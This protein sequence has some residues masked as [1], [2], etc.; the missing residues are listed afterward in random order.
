MQEIFTQNTQEKHKKTGLPIMLHQRVF[1]TYNIVHCIIGNTHKKN[2]IKKITS[3]LDSLMSRIENGQS[4]FSE[5]GGAEIL[6]MINTYNQLKNDEKKEVFLE[7]GED[8]W[9]D[10]IR[11]KMQYHTLRRES[12]DIE[13]SKFEELTKK[14]DPNFDIGLLNSEKK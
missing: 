4:L 1:S 12:S 10:F 14:L 7:Y 5:N 11:V 6:D 9:D 13:K 2:D 3:T 8:F